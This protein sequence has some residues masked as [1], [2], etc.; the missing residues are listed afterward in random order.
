M[1]RTFP[2]Q[3]DEQAAFLGFHYERGGDLA[4]ASYFQME[5]ADQLRLLYA[6]DEAVSLYH[7]VLE[8][9]AKQEASG[10]SLDSERRVRTYL[11][12]AQV[13]GNR[14][15][16]VNAQR[17]YERAFE[18]MTS[19]QTGRP[20]EEES[21]TDHVIRLGVL[22]GPLALD[23]AF[24]DI[25][26]V[27]EIVEDLFEGL[28]EL[29]AELNVIPAM[30]MRWHVDEGGR[31][32]RFELRPDLR[33]SDGM[34]LTAHDFVFAWRRNLDPETGAGRASE[35][36]VV[37]GAEAYHQG[38]STDPASIGIE[39]LDERNLEVRLAS[40]TGYFPKL[41]AQP[42]MFPQPE[43][44][45]HD[46]GEKWSRPENVVGNG[47]Y[48]ITRWESGKEICLERNPYFRSHTAGNVGKVILRYVYPGLDQYLNNEIDWCKV[49]DQ[50][51][52]AVRYPNEAS[53]LQYLYTAFIGFACTCPPFDQSLVRK[54]FALAVDQT[55]LANDVWRGVQRPALGGAVPPG[56]PGHSPEIG[57]PYDPEAAR[58]LL[59]QAGY[60]SGDDFPVV[61]LVTGGPGFNETPHYLQ[62][63][64]QRHLGVGV[65]V[66]DD[67]AIDEALDQLADSAVHLLLF[68]YHTDLADPDPYLA[69]FKSSSPMNYFGWRN[70]HFDRVMALA[71]QEVDQQQR[72][73]LCHEAD[74]IFV[75]ESAGAIPLYYG[76]AYAL[77]RPGFHIAGAEK[78]LR[79]GVF[80]LKNIVAA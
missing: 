57:Q 79:G 38:K 6:H 54:A 30:A 65:E 28:V 2:G 60:S 49:E 17:H 7:K 61:K 1:E 13:E 15:D 43:H 21:A 58:E 80:R 53:V 44:I 67:V 27:S 50:P 8:L 48:R 20:A 72:I 70:G 29:D 37:L 71:A 39:A 10:G 74:R 34:P 26:D 14:L 31:L 22:N 64:W 77:M 35:L 63:C 40:P 78:I 55:E 52:L 46:A 47:A 41:L 23:P 12:L 16:F 51:D 33:W 19:A 24:A 5:A 9:L 66:I 36:Y 45:I 18:L 42:I 4:Q 59:R 75:S 32:Y 11:K 3:I 25:K 76:R 73:A 62:H 69:T 56:M 68:V